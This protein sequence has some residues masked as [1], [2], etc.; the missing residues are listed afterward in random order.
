[1]DELD[2]LL[3][4]GTTP[5][6]QELEWDI[7]EWFSAPTTIEQTLVTAFI[8]DTP[9]EQQLPSV[10]AGADGAPPTSSTSPQ[11]LADAQKDDTSSPGE[12]PPHFS[13]PTEAEMPQGR[14]LYERIVQ[15]LKIPISAAEIINLPRVQFSLKVEELD[16]GLATVAR[17]IRKR[18]RATQRSALRKRRIKP[19]KNERSEAAIEYKKAYKTRRSVEIAKAAKES[20]ALL[21]KA[22]SANIP[23]AKMAEFTLLRQILKERLGAEDLVI[24]AKW[25]TD[26]D[27]EL[28]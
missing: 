26:L 7:E 28:L 12:S 21:K 17:D 22:K 13:L 25:A 2:Q 10:W 15:D 11:H 8:P 20:A 27:Y 23:V 14:A 1:M 6:L 4:E 3:L 9:M 16:E 24:Y 5:V 19:T 18:G